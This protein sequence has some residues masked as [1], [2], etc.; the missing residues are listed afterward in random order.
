MKTFFV[1]G[2]CS[3]NK[4][5]RKLVFLLQTIGA[6]SLVIGRPMIESDQGLSGW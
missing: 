2:F 5:K 4:E 6:F 3:E 1:L